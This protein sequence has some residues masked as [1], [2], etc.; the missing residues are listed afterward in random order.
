MNRKDYPDNWEEI[1]QYIRFE[2]AKG[3]CECEGECGI[4]H[5]GRCQAV[6]GKSNPMT[7]SKVILT[8]MHMNHDTTDNRDENLKA[9]CQRCH[10]RYDAG[11]HARN[12]AKTFRA[13]KACGDLFEEENEK[14][15]D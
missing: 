5:D 1:S 2:R 4:D 3:R 9:G 8:T 15:D 10:L 6:H 13:K 14:V 12:A 11:H 7:G